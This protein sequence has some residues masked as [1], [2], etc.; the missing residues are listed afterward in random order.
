MNACDCHIKVI[1]CNPGPLTMNIF[2]VKKAPVKIVMKSKKYTT[3]KIPNK[4][5]V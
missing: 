5:R 1:D 4:Y 3:F 2:Y